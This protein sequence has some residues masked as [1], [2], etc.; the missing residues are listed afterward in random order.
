MFATLLYLRSEIELPHMSEIEYSKIFYNRAMQYGTLLGAL[1][2]IMYLI[3]FAG[4]RSTILLPFG[5]LILFSSPFIAAAYAR[6]YRRQECND[7]MSYTKAL[8]FL[9]V[10][11]LC[12]TLLSTAVI[13]VYINYIDNGAFIGTVLEMIAMLENAPGIQADTSEALRGMADIYGR[14]TPDD[15]VWTT[16]DGNITNSLLLPLIIALFIRKNR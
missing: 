13:F 5:L 10:M 3:F 16:M 11:Y 6:R 12:A 7:T 14:M 1:W 15:F 9:I 2:S 8:L 4:I